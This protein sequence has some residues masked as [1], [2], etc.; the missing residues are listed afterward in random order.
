MTVLHFQEVNILKRIY[1][2]SNMV[3]NMRGIVLKPAGHAV[4]FYCFG[5]AFT[6]AGFIWFG[7]VHLDL[8][9][10]IWIWLGVVLLVRCGFIGVFAFR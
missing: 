5:L 7:F 8:V 3:C 10:F 1:F 6:V 9:L 4:Y 2:D